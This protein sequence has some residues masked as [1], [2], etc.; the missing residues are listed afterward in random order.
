MLAN[1]YVNVSPLEIRKSFGS[2]FAE[3]VLQLET[4]VWIGPVLSGYGTHLVYIAD[5]QL[6]EVPLLADIK[7]IVLQ[8]YLAEEKMKLVKK[9]IEKVIEKYNIVIVADAKIEK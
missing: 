8:D 3:S 7:E 1:T 4:N 6:P 2:G 9:Y 5:K